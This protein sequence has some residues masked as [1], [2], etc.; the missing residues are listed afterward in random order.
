M[1]K[2]SCHAHYFLLIKTDLDIKINGVSNVEPLHY[3]WAELG[4]IAGVENV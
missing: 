1:G 4:E 2:E 3:D